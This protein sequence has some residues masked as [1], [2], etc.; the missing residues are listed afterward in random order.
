M[1][2]RRKSSPKHK[3]EQRQKQRVA[4]KKDFRQVDEYIWEL[5]ADFRDNMR[6][7]ARLFADE[8]LFDAVFRDRTIIQLANVATLPGI[9]KHAKSENIEITAVCD[10]WR[11]RQ[12]A[13]SAQ[14][15]ACYGR[16]ARR[17]QRIVPEIATGMCSLDFDTKVV[18]KLSTIPAPPWPGSR[19]AA[20][21]RRP[22]S[23]SG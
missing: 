19:M 2:R 22:S 11:L 18:W 10:P 1:A 23:R 7:P 13:A 17:W 3:Q 14:A 8:E 9:V 21:T 16:A 4:Q 20:I 12:A 6:V 15:K 5:P